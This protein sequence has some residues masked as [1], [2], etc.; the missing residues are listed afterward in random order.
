MDDGNDNA[1]FLHDLKDVVSS[2]KKDEYMTCPSG[3]PFIKNTDK[4]N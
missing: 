1:R 2:G 3:I 4:E